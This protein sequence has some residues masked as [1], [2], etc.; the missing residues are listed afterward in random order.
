MKK[1]G[2]I[3]IICVQLILLSSC[4]H[5]NVDPKLKGIDVDLNKTTYVL[6]HINISDINILKEE[7]SALSTNIKTAQIGNDFQIIV[8]IDKNQSKCLFSEV[9][10]YYKNM[11][12][13]GFTF[14]YKYDESKNVTDE[15]KK[16]IV[17][18]YNLEQNNYIIGEI[19]K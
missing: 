12:K 4:N 18:L 3:I 6:P 7:L 17:K 10:Y 13:D 5:D 2:I 8:K 15:M 1:I 14:T 19:T 16:E 9:T 11:G